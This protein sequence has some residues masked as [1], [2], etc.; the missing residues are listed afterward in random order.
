MA[1]F[2]DS[3]KL[4][5]G[6]FNPEERRGDIERAKELG[7][8]LADIFTE[9]GLRDIDLET[10][11]GSVLLRRID[12]EKM[13]MIVVESTDPAMRNEEI[14]FLEGAS[15]TGGSVVPGLLAPGARLAFRKRKTIKLRRGEKDEAGVDGIDTVSDK[16]LT[17]LQEA[18]PGS[19][20]PPN[21]EGIIKFYHF[22]S[23]ARA[24]D[25]VSH[26]SV[27]TE[28]DKEEERKYLF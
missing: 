27:V 21:E 10:V 4:P 2:S 20:A 3:S 6:V 12:P 22:H 1:E 11:T 5:P 15:M 13:T 9:P 8:Q 7:V 28:I 18:M 25:F 14:V 16:T 17:E 26:C 24:T 23:G 19:V